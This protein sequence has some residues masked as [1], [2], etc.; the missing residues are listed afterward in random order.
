MSIECSIIIPVYNGESTIE[1]A[2]RS[3]LSNLPERAEVVVVDD[4][5][6]DRTVEVVRQFPVTLVSHDVNKGPSAA[7]NTGV[8]RSNGELLVFVDA[9]VQLVQ[10]A[11]QH[12]LAQLRSTPS[13]YGANGSVSLDIPYSDLVTDF[14]NTSLHFQLKS[15]G[16]LVNTCFTSLC[17]IRRSAF[18][19]MGGWDEGQVSRYVDDVNTRWFFP[20]GSIRQVSTAQFVHHKQV[21]LRGLL[22][23]RANV[24]FH[25]VRNIRNQAASTQEAV[26]KSVINRRYPINTVLGALFVPS[27]IFPPGTVVVA[28]LLVANNLEFAVFTLRKRGILRSSA[29]VPLSLLEGMAYAV[30]MCKGIQNEF[31]HSK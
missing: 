17:I 30:G 3:V 20:Q 25:F 31:F 4:A 21:R 22:K 19:Q 10:G 26:Q 6:T 1:V 18:E 11:L 27:L 12:L 23:H 7:R 8:Q 24:G 28:G 15:H 5:S 13:L 16:E 2:L 29:V 14:V 9:D